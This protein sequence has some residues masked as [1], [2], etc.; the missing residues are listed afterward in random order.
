MAIVFIATK[1]NGTDVSLVFDGLIPDEAHKLMDCLFDSKMDEIL[2]E[3]DYDITLGYSVNGYR[4]TEK[5]DRIVTKDLCLFVDTLKENEE[6][7]KRLADLI[8]SETK[9]EAMK[10]Y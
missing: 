1:S 9:I 4:T 5:G 6:Y 7:L 3:E 8:L 2:M 10:D